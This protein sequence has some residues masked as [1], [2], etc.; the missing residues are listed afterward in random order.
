MFRSPVLSAGVAM[1]ALVMT[2]MMATL[3]VGPFYLSQAL[4]LDA[5][6]VGV[7][8]SV[9]PLVAA[10]SGVPAGRIVDRLGAQRM[11]IGGLIGIAAGSL[12]LSMMPAKRDF[13][14]ASCARDA[15]SSWSTYVVSVAAKS[16]TN[17]VT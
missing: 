11:T 3:M 14:P 6:I 2:V 13:P 8:M 16:T 17:A 15:E 7:V 12:I 10:L 4:G 1:S 5:A 9:G